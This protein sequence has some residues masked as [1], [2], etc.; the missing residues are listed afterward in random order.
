[1]AFNLKTYIKKNYLN[2]SIQSDFLI[3]SL[4]NDRGGFF[5]YYKFPYENTRY[6]RLQKI[7]V[8]MMQI[9]RTVYGKEVK[10]PTV[11]PIEINNDEDAI[12]AYKKYN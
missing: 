4:L 5:R 6:G 8:D 7:L 12:K 9:I 10:R 3:N 1:M 11:D 2:E